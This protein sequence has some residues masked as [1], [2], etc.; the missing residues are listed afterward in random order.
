MLTISLR[1]FSSHYVQEIIEVNRD[2]ALFI[3]RVAV[4]I[5]AGDVII[6]VADEL[7]DLFFLGFEAEGAESYFQVL[8]V[9]HTLAIGIE[10]VECLPDFS[11]LNISKFL[12]VSFGI[13]L[14]FA[15]TRWGAA[16]LLG[17]LLDRCRW[18][19]VLY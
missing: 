9:D 17:Q 8:E 18:L 12:L 13:F 15:G 4:L 6:L 11:F 2:L 1:H 10:E 3:S 14:L 16:S 19:S 7:L 5:S